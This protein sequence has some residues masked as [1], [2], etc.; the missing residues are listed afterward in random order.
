MTKFLPYLSLK[1]SAMF[2]K[3]SFILLSCM[4]S[5]DFLFHLKNFAMS[6]LAPATEINYLSEQAEDFVMKSKVTF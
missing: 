6:E 5:D 1:P 2:E 4:T 3:R